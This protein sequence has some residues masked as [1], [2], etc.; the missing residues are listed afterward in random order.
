MAKYLA[1]CNLGETRRADGM[2][3]EGK[4][5]LW[6]VVRREQEPHSSECNQ[7]VIFQAWTSELQGMGRLTADHQGDQSGK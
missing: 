2:C 5:M 1:K 4:N 6:A 3:C 7:K